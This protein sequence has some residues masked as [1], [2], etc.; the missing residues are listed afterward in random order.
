MRYDYVCEN[1][2]TIHEVIKPMRLS[3]CAENCTRC[4]GRMVKKI[5]APSIINT[6][7]SFGIGRNFIDERTNKEITTWK[8][9]EKA[10][11]R[12]PKSY[13]R[14]SNVVSGI[15]RKENKINKYDNKKRFT[16]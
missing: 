12:E 8:E 16:V 2:E 4:K 3:D 14:D 6:R 9:W 1:C 15:K 13:H 7:D 10:G 11:Y 5:T